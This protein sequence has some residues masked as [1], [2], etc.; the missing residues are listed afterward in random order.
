[1]AT[2]T[3]CKPRS[4]FLKIHH[5]N[6]IDCRGGVRGLAL[7]G[8]LVGWLLTCA[9]LAQHTPPGQSPTANAQDTLP[10]PVAPKPE[11]ETGDLPE[12]VSAELLEPGKWKCVFRFK[13]AKPVESV[14]L[15]GVFNNWNPAGRKMTGPD[16]TGFYSGE[17]E[18]PSGEHL[19]KFVVE[20]EHWFHDPLNPNK[21]DD[22]HQGFNSVLRLGRL[23]AIKYSPAKR[24]DGQVDAVG[25]EHRSELPMYFQPLSPE[26]VLIRYR[27]LARDAER[28][29]V[30][31]RGGAAHEMAL[32]K[33]DA[34]FA[35][36]EA[37]ADVPPSPKKPAGKTQVYQV[38]YSFV[39][40]D[41]K[42]SV[43][44]PS[45]YTSN[46][47]DARIFRTPAWARDAVWYQIMP[48]RFR[49]ASSANDPENT[50]P[51]TSDWF[52]AS[53]WETKDGQTF[54]KHFVFRRM[55]GGD[56]EGVEQKLDYLKELGVN[57]IYFNPV[58]Q[59]E[60]HHKYNATSYVH[61][62][63]RFGAKGGFEA[64]TQK[65]DLLDPKTWTWTES[66]KRFLKFLQVAKSK[67][68]R[69]IIDGVF[70]H[71]GDQHPAFLDVKKNGQKSRYADWF[72]VVR[73]EPFEHR[74]WG[75]FGDL[76]S[77]RKTASDLA[78]ET[79]K[80]HIF[81]VTRRWMDPNGDG[82]PA[83]GIDGW[84]LDVPNEV[85]LPFWAEWR[86]LVK[87]VNPDAYIVGEIW[88]RADQWLDG[89]HFDAVMNYEFARA[90]IAWI[91]HQKRKPKISEVDRKLRELRLAYPEP[92][93]YVMQNLVD[94]HDTDRIAS[95]LLNPDRDY[96]RMNRVQDDNPNYD[97]AK[98]GPEV[99][100]RQRLVA[101]TQMTYVGAPMIYY[102]DEVGMWGADDPTCRKPMLWEDLQPYAKPEENFVMHDML[103]HY[104]K[105]IALRN[106]HPALRS[107]GFAT[108]AT[109]DEKDVWAFLRANE[110]E[111]LIV[112]LNAS[113]REAEIKLTLPAGMPTSWAGVYGLSS[114]VEVTGG[115]ISIKVP[116]IDG[117]VLRAALGK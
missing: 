16:A 50:R 74:G 69:V 96:D 55:Y 10:P 97:N 17:I 14:Y 99:Y 13:P 36:Y 102:G 65:E 116:K 114:N 70:N 109:D 67:G 108:L 88:D 8:A 101:L 21:V 79:L 20:G 18:L 107:G 22:G 87:S 110:S 45:T 73:W 113:E 19:Y 95:M 104:R 51:W 81:A 23:A 77:F 94:S 83:D 89:R 63:D 80:N 71:V 42:L 93:T 25:L 54:Y 112:A 1:M 5:R 111:A 6:H 105:V 41:G 60:S 58:F 24:G 82:N 106:A 29:V 117:V 49:N 66:D 91:G 115:A 28:V 56:L 72:D 98:P 35:W 85:P 76:P 39:L 11:N 37:H 32:V 46:F 12:S 7:R 103:A 52:E 59:A 90:V 100:Q 9:V 47:V 31:V 33:E 27:T 38:D 92:A 68:F 53:P 26:Q 48:D 43:S 78:S 30:H 84:R 57:A 15:T 62:D 64:A 40:H 44:D 3:H 61:I 4:T 34:V 2:M 75:G 86:Q